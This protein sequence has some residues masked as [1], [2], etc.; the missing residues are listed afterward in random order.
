M[1]QAPVG[2]GMRNGWNC[3]SVKQK[4]PALQE[5][6]ARPTTRYPRE[7]LNLWPLPPQGSALS[8]E[9]LG[10]DYPDNRGQAGRAGFEPAKDV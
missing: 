10:H 1:R 7:D 4:E 2:I 3:G 6:R 9:L 8:T 5:A